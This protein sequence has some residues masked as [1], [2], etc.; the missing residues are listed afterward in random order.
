M[1][2]LL[3]GRGLS[4]SAGRVVAGGRWRGVASLVVAKGGGG[5]GGGVI[6]GKRKVHEAKTVNWSW[7]WQVVG[8]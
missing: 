3:L 1:C 4:S 6:E 5:R 7:G 2:L 8:R